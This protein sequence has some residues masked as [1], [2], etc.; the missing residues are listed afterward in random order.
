MTRGQP[1]LNGQPGGVEEFNTELERRR[2][3]LSQIEET[4]KSATSHEQILE[5]M[6]RISEETKFVHRLSGSSSSLQTA[7]SILNLIRENS[8]LY[9]LATRRLVELEQKSTNSV[10]PTTDNRQ[11]PA[12]PAR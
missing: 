9:N 10:R 3:M 7:A 12:P 5:Q 2:D 6:R 11:P 8:R 4:I 1:E